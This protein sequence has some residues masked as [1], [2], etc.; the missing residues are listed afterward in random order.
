MS[1]GTLDILPALRSPAW[2][3]EAACRGADPELF[4]TH[5]GRPSEPQ[6]AAEAVGVCNRCPVRP[7]CLLWAFRTADRWAILGGKTPKE[8]KAIMR[9]RTPRTREIRDRILA[10]LGRGSPPKAAMP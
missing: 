2:M 1:T 10:S 5:P 9:A 3:R 8:R 7:E 6:R 4:F